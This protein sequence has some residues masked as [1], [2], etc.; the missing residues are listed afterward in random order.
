METLSFY[1]YLVFG[2]TV[3]LSVFLFYRA[4][5]HSK[6]FLYLIAIWLLLQ[7][8][9]GISGFYT[10]VTTPPRLPLLV[11]PPVLF[12]VS[13]FNTGKGK[14]F[15]DGLDV[16]KITLVHVIRIPVE[17]VLLWLCIHKVVPELVTFEGRNF[18]I[19]SG[20][21]APLVYYFGFVKQQLSKPIL[22]LWNFICLGLLA[23]VVAYALLSAPSPLQQ[24]AFDQPNIAISYFPFLLLPS[25]LVPLV[26]FS[27]LVSIRQ[28]LKP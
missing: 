8:I 26:L 21:T 27:H 9:L 19:L 16:K 1:V 7:S 5:D 17:I 6:S 23:N 13:L 18:D 2:L 14:R 11:L 3:L 12:I 22:L 15:I 4:T 24:F 10:T 20:I 28:L 25:V